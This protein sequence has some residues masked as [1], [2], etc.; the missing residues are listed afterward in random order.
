MKKKNW[1][2]LQFIEKTSCI[3]CKWISK[4]IRF[5]AVVQLAIKPGKPGVSWPSTRYRIPCELCDTSVVSGKS[6]RSSA[7]KNV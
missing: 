6:L 5:F 7:S 4:T 3:S 2:L 1:D